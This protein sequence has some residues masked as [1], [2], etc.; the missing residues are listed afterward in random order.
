[1]NTPKKLSKNF[2]TLKQS[3]QHKKPSWNKALGDLLNSSA[4]VKKKP[5]KPAS[6]PT[7]NKSDAACRRAKLESDYRASGAL[8]P[9]EAICAVC[10]VKAQSS[11]M[12]R[13][14]PAGRRKTAFCFTVLLHSQCHRKVH[15]NP[16]WAQEQGLL[17]KG[18]NSKVFT[19]ADAVG[20]VARWP[21]PCF[22]P[23]IILKQFSPD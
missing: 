2:S 10:G 13:H 12:E 3:K 14:H 1:M 8:L 9:T 4:Q 23:L 16:L 21:F 19:Y 15:E 6:T 18:R 7:K 17:W 22:Y 11:T 20:L 5:N